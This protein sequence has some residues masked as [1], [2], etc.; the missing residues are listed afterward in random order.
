MQHPPQLCHR[1]GAVCPAVLGVRRAEQI[2]RGSVQET[3][4][5]GRGWGVLG[6]PVLPA[7]FCILGMFMFMFMF[8]SLS[9]CTSSPTSNAHLSFSLSFLSSLNLCC[10]PN[11][12]CCVNFQLSHV[13]TKVKRQDGSYRAQIDGTKKHTILSVVSS[14]CMYRQRPL[15][16]IKGCF[17]AKN[18]KIELN[19]KHM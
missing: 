14:A 8:L 6:L 10:T 17:S 11:R 19:K 3:S 12:S 13:H 18:K 16:R 2:A 15:P 1:G 7:R 5:R 4:T 9:S